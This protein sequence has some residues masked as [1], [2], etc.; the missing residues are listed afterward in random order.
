MT[1]VR[2][3]LELLR[4]AMDY[5]W[6]DL[7]Y[8]H[9]LHDTDFGALDTILDAA[10]FLLSLLDEGGRLVVETPCPDGLMERHPTRRLSTGVGIGGWCPGGSRT[11][12]WHT[13]KEA[14]RNPNE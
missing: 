9:S 14:W 12:V 10:R 5:G 4:A 1:V 7:H 6:Q 13:D 2:L 11:V 3:D 8:G